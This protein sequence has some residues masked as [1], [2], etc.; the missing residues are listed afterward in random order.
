[1]LAVEAVVDEQEG[2]DRAVAERGRSADRRR[3]PGECRLMASAFRLSLAIVTLAAA[4]LLQS[5]AGAPK[6]GVAATSEPVPTTKRYRY[7]GKTMGSP[8]EITIDERNDAE[9]KERARAAARAALDELDRLD[10]ILSDWKRSSE[11]TA[12]NDSRDARRAMNADFCAVLTRALEV[13]AA[14][15]GI[16][17]PTIGPLVAL[18]R[19]SRASMRLPS[20]AERDAAC[21][22][23]DWRRVSVEGSV[24]SRLRTDVRLDFGGIGKG[25]AAIRAL[26]TLRANGCP[27]ALVAVA[28]DIAAGAPPSDAPAWMIEIAPE[29]EGLAAESVALVE[30]AISTSGGSMQW[31]EIDGVRYAHIVDPRTGLGATNLAQVTVI[32]PLDCAVDALGTALALTNDD[33]EAAAI[34]AK[35]HGYRARIERDGMVA[36]IGDGERSRGR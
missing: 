23:V 16:F 34:M 1:V 18:W 36:W 29:S 11:L 14:T 10:V 5:C 22:R 9:G 35:F 20:Q 25:F 17:D 12:F 32:G 26:E 3:D 13:A 33:S 4:P 8:V 30:S 19:E 21:A 27:R 2:A 7:L 31:V 6:P 28:G 24:V 15:D